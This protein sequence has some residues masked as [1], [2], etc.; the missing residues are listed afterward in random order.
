M[1][2]ITPSGRF[3]RLPLELLEGGLLNQLTST[4]LN[5]LLWIIRHD[6]Y[7]SHGIEI[8]LSIDTLK[9]KLETSR[10]SVYRAIEGLESK[11]LVTKTEKGNGWVF[12]P[13]LAQAVPELTQDCAKI[14]TES[15]GKTARKT[16]T[17]RR[18]DDPA[19]GSKRR[20]LRE[21]ILRE[22]RRCPMPQDL[23]VPNASLPSPFL[24][25]DSPERMVSINHVFRDLANTFTKGAYA[26][27]DQRST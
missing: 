17:E 12:V 20:L 9:T 5:L 27:A 8:I 21:D 19:P 1:A 10:R 26:H 25:K 15:A 13:K 18:S 3:V 11:G 24:N 2:K 23:N 4:E 6:P 22:D 14:G 16:A 7:S